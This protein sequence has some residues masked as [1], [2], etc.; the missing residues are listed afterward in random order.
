MRITYKTNTSTWGAKKKEARCMAPSEPVS[1]NYL[2]IPGRVLACLFLIIMIASFSGCG[3]KFGVNIFF[4]VTHFL[5]EG[6]EK[7]LK[8]VQVDLLEHPDQSPLASVK[9]RDSGGGEFELLPEQTYYLRIHHPEGFKRMIVYQPLIHLS[10]AEK[11][12]QE[13]HTTDANQNDLKNIDEREDILHPTIDT[14]VPQ[15]E[16]PIQNDSTLVEIQADSWDR[17]RSIAT[18]REIIYFKY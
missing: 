16:T 4:S 12:E 7:P 3:N 14:V 13:P 5:D 9:T 18:I 10:Q 2:Y 1:Q 11:D 8:D 6:W 15:I 17:L